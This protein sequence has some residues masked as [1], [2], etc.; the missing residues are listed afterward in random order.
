MEFIAN[1]KFLNF[2]IDEKLIS[3]IEGSAALDKFNK[4][5]SEA[6]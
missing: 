3:A 5:N 6:S 4:N 2:L 1:M